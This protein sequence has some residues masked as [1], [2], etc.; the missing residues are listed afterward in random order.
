[1]P[2]KAAPDLPDVFGDA[3]V[4][5]RYG[6]TGDAQRKTGGKKHNP[7]DPLDLR[8]IEPQPPSKKS[9]QQ[10]AAAA[11][12]E[13]G[14]DPN[15]KLISEDE[16]DTR[17]TGIRN[18]GATCYMNSLLQCLFMNPRF[19]RCIFQWD[20]SQTAREEDVS[21]V[22]MVSELQLLFAHLLESSR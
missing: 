5:A 10:Q 3:Y 19:R 21:H 4:A 9:E 14:E 6:L 16:R 8:G 12:R 2:A 7:S 1:M 11:A 13:L 22:Q 17:R 15:D 20:A 18:L